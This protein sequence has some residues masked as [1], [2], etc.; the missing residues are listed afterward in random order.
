M[1]QEQQGDPSRLA[2]TGIPV[3]RILRYVPLVWDS[4]ETSILR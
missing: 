3:V 4:N 1:L 2:G